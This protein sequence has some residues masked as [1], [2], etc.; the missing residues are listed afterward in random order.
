MPTAVQKFL[1]FIPLNRRKFIE[2][3]QSAIFICHRQEISCVLNADSLYKCMSFPP[4]KEYADEAECASWSTSR[5]RDCR[6]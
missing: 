2:F 5:E 6:R 3:G 1:V 4:L